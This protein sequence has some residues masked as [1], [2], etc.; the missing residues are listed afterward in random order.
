MEKFKNRMSTNPNR[1][2]LEKVGI[3]AN[4]N[5][6]VDIKRH[7]GTVS[8]AGT[9]LNAVKLNELLA[10]ATKINMTVENDTLHITISDPVAD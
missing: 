2:I 1:R 6:I 8:E 4:G 5:D 7:E 3:D 10:L 9:P